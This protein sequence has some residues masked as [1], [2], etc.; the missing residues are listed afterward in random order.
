MPICHIPDKYD[1]I[2]IIPNILDIKIRVKF[3]ISC[4]TY[5]PA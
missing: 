5:F 3:R 4:L 1:T 2:Y